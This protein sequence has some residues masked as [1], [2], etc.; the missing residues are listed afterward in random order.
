MMSLRALAAI[1]TG[2]FLLMLIGAVPYAS[3]Q[4]SDTYVPTMTFASATLHDSDA[5]QT[6]DLAHAFVLGTSAFGVSNC[7]LTS[8]IAQAYGLRPDQV[9]GVPYQIT[10]YD[11]LAKADSPAEAHIATL[12]SKQ[13]QLEQHH[14]LQAMLADRFKLQVHSESRTVRSYDLI[15]G[16]LGPMMN[17]AAAEEASGVDNK[18]LSPLSLSGDS[19]AGFDCLA[20]GA[21]MTDLASLLSEQFNRPVFDRTGLTGRYDFELR[22]RGLIAHDRD[23]PTMDA[24]PP[25]DQAIQ[26]QLGLRLRPTRG[27]E[28]F[29]VV[30]HVD[31]PTLD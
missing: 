22:Y 30:D 29:L 23:F 6:C 17:L 18:N 20:Q 10:T 25:L 24:L 12:D 14:M 7:D 27:L 8:L 15:A 13:Q 2:P 16:K 28:L 3:A 11:I 1:H 4:T 5:T 9:V 21:S 19:A 31:K 26:W